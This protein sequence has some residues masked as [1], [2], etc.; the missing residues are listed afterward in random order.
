[1]SDTDN[2]ID[3]A[4]ARVDELLMATAQESNATTLPDPAP[5]NQQMALKRL[6]ELMGQVSDTAIAELRELREGIDNTIRQIQ[7]KHV[8]LT[9][10][11]AHHVECVLE[12]MRFRTIAS[13]HLDNVRDRFE[14]PTTRKT[15]TGARS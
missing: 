5:S 14:I 7:S 3:G 15:H 8:A 1:M 10:D 2:H 13:E 11:F 4:L 12:A 9:A 6:S